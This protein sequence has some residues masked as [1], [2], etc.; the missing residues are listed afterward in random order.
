MG[1]E[2]DM[3]GRGFST[4]SQKAVMMIPKM[5][6]VPLTLTYALIPPISQLLHYIHQSDSNVPDPKAIWPIDL[7]TRI[8]VISTLRDIDGY[9]R[10]YSLHTYT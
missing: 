7:A 4:E 2:L 9:R 8:F 3:K 1:V 5:K 6:E 10:Y